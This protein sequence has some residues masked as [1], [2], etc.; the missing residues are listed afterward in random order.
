MRC[1]GVQESKRYVAV[2][3]VIAGLDG[4]REFECSAVLG[5]SV[6]DGRPADG[7]KGGGD[8]KVDQ[9]ALGQHRS[10]ATDFHNEGLFHLRGGPS[11]VPKGIVLFGATGY[12]IWLFCQSSNCPKSWSFSC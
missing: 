9:A 7:E 2:T 11:K 4:N 12:R 5:A 8:N 1:D 3:I 6:G 10:R